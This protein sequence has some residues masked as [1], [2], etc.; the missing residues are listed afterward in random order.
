MEPRKKRTAMA[1]VLHV[2]CLGRVTIPIYIRRLL[3]ISEN[4]QVGFGVEDGKIVI[5][6]K[7]KSATTSVDDVIRKLENSG[8]VTKEE[9]IQ[10]CNIVSKVIQLN[11]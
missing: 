3:D 11:V 4:D 8:D 5:F 2:D 6:N 1:G 10:V 7:N 9:Y